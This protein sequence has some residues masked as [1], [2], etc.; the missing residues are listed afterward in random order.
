MSSRERRATASCANART[1]A[2]GVEPP[3]VLALRRDD[4]AGACGVSEETFDKHIRPS[5]PVVRLGTVRVYP[6]EDLQVW[7]REHAVAPV[8]ELTER[9]A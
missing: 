9:A 5:L 4:A 8:D 1:R 6:V 2:Q 3:V 7:L